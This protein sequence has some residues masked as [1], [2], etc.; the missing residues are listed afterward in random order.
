MVV[1]VVLL[2]CRGA[3][4]DDSR[5]ARPPSLLHLPFPPLFTCAILLDRSSRSSSSSNT[6]N[7][8]VFLFANP[9]TLRVQQSAHRHHHRTEEELNYP[10]L[11]SAWWPRSFLHTPSPSEIRFSPV[12]HSMQRMFGTNFCCCCGLA[13]SLALLGHFRVLRRQADRRHLRC[14]ACYCENCPCGRR[15]AAEWSLWVEGERKK[16]RSEKLHLSHNT[17]QEIDL[18]PISP[19][20]TEKRKRA[21]QRV[22]V[23]V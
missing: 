11:S 21:A 7:S 5:R 10:V 8:S 1:V 22:C 23:C 4:V 14:L 13:F 6:K 17:P 16:K 3:L 19:F 20:Q 15:D 18:W 2:P 12:H 9:P